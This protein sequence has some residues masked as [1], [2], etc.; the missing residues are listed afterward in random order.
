MLVFLLTSIVYQI[1]NK[2]YDYLWYVLRAD[3]S[4]QMHASVVSEAA[5]ESVVV[6]SGN[7]LHHHIRRG[8][9]WPGVHGITD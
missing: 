4:L 3:R 9:L 8:P 1:R 2:Q 5:N 6:F 7:D